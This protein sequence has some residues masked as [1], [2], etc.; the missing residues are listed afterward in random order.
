[1][2][3]WILDI[4]T[5][6]LL[7]EATQI[8]CIVVQNIA[9]DEV[10][11]FD[12][13][14]M[15]L[16]ADF[17]ENEDNVFIGHNAIAFDFPVIK[18]LLGLELPWKRMY[19]TL[20]ISRMLQPDRLSGHSL[21][22]YGVEFGYP[23]G[24]FTDFS[25]YTSEMLEYCKRDVEITKKSWDKFNPYIERFGKA[26]DID[27]EFA[28]YL[29]LQEANG[30]TLNVGRT[31]DLSRTLD[32]E[33]AQLYTKLLSLIPQIKKE[34]PAYKTAKKENRLLDEDELSFSYITEKTKVLKSK[35]FKYEDLNSNSRQQIVDLLIDKYDWQP[36]KYTEKG[37]PMVDG[38]VLGS[39]D[40]PEAQLLYKMHDITK[41]LGQLRDGRQ[42]WLKNVS[43]VGRVYGS[44]IINGATGG[45]CTH[46]LIANINKDPRMRECWIPRDTWGLVGCDASGLE[47]RVLSHYLANW[48]KGAYAHVVTTGDIHVHNQRVM[49]L[50]E[51]NTAKTAIYA[52]IYG[53]G[54]EKLGQTVKK[55]LGVTSDATNTLIKV[56][57]GVRDRIQDQLTGYKEIMDTIEETL[58]DRD[59][60]IGIDGRPLFP[61]NNYSALNL[62]IQ[63][64]GAS[65]MKK[66]LNNFMRKTKFLGLKHGVDFGLVANIHDEQQIEAP[67]K[68]LDKLK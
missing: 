10:R 5:D 3:K 64:A 45:R 67:N 2:S 62:L 52:L 6:G 68:L 18:R 43:Q 42:S 13:K 33:K 14:N 56:G 54:N 59:Y 36:K 16:F 63:S 26:I 11:V 39:L 47:L 9:T 4:E 29:S 27:R 8:W 46:K 55:D 34:C 35:D 53:A 20:I 58:K 60:L 17:Y 7:R 48:D 50:N 57:K 19:D 61:R 32:V 51:R 1:M 37:N 31:A 22:S 15:P 44:V 12:N 38:Q 21:A 30:F 24:D 28:Y 65:I 66:A 40:Y 25:Q 49:G 41:K 23:K